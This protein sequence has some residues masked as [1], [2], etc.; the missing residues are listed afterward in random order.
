MKT[1]NQILELARERMRLRHFALNTEKAYLGWIARYHAHVIAG[2][3]DLAP[4]KK[5]EAYLTDLAT[6]HGVAARTQ[7]QALAAILF[8]YSHV[9]GRPLGDISAMRAR[10]PA[11]MRSAPSREQIRIFRAAVKDTPQTPARLLVDLIYG[12]G[13]RVSEPLELRIKDIL[14]GERQILVRD[15]KG[16]KD[17][18]V[19]IPRSCTEA[20]RHQM[21]R[22]RTL[23]EWDRR[24]APG[25]GVPLPY[26]L[27]KKYPAARFAWQWFWIFPAAGH[28]K[29]PYSDSQLRFHILVDS[30]QRSVKEAANKVDLG[31]L[32]TP[33]VLRHAFATHMLAAGT[34]VR[35]IAELMGHSSIETTAGYLHPNVAGALSPLDDPLFTPG[36]EFSPDKGPSGCGSVQ[37]TQAAYG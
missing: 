32:I 11:R 19:P 5:A 27:A 13:M 30:L 16:G 4:E 24:N 2:R 26:Q 33:H 6:R 3:S 23:W 12:T 7:N 35:T 22:A 9:L 21:G 17:R 37:E 18:R 8:L 29:D 28:C 10:A 34:D 25:V 20:L 31:G 15:A 14:W 36:P 1:L